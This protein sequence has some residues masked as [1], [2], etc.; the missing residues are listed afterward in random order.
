MVH[1]FMYYNLPKYTSFKNGDFPKLHETTRGQDK[2]K[3][4]TATPR[5][6]DIW[7]C[8]FLS[9]VMCSWLRAHGSETL[10]TENVCNSHGYRMGM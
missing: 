7:L 3:Q 9:C 10:V 4:L 1:L 6:C 8:R 2:K 5:D